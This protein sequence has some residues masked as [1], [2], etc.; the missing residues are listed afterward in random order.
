MARRKERK[1][2]VEEGKK[3]ININAIS[4]HRTNNN[5]K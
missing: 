2:K 3:S 1:K 5:L 4:S